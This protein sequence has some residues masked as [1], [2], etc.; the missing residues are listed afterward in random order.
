LLIFAQRRLRGCRVFDGQPSA[1]A[2]A[3]K[4][5]PGG[6]LGGKSIRGHGLEMI[7]GSNAP[8]Q[9]RHRH[10]AIGHGAFVGNIL[11]DLDLLRLRMLK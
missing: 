9:R 3:L 10:C 7:L 1:C 5:R 2:R 6:H 11:G 8:K 4:Q